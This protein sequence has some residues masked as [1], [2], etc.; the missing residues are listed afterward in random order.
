MDDD[1]SST[2]PHM[3]ASMHT[4]NLAGLISSFIFILPLS[5]QE[6]AKDTISEIV[7]VEGVGPSPEEAI[8]DAFRKAVLQVGGSVINPETQIKKFE[9]INEEV[10]VDNEIDGARKL[11]G[12]FY[13]IG[14]KAEVEKKSL[15]AK[16]RSSK[17]MMH[18]VDQDILITTMLLEFRS[19]KNASAIL[20]RQFEAFPQSCLC[21][22]VI[23]EPKVIEEDCKNA[24]IEIMVQIEPD[25]EAC[26]ALF[27]T[28][29]SAL[30]TMT[31]Y[32]RTESYS[33][34]YPRENQRDYW[35]LELHSEFAKNGKCDWMVWSYED[36][37]PISIE[38]DPLL[39][40]PISPSNIFFS[41]RTDFLKVEVDSTGSEGCKAYSTHRLDPSLGEKMEQLVKKRGCVSLELLDA[42]NKR[43]AVAKMNLHQPLMNMD[44]WNGKAI[45]YLNFTFVGMLQGGRP[46]SYTHSIK[47]PFR[48]TLS[49]EQLKM[50]N[51]IKVDV[52]FEE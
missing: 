1:S 35:S 30:H 2:L 51:D 34:F 18:R 8:K 42:K 43:I 11:N 21:A 49:L 31:S 4:W 32:N 19:K 47:T 24:T 20:E 50:L 37:I 12:S 25:K 33:G 36:E 38:K 45:Y 41:E 16:L 15:L 46:H 13:R 44:K 3:E 22:T 29:D 52:Q 17:V 26:L 28:L 6:P 10:G 7:V 23:G 5:A 40:S 9:V 27:R 48:I 14:I 39:K